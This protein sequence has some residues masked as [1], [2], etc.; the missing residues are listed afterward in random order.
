MTAASILRSRLYWIVLLLFL[1]TFLNYLDRQTLSI[2]KPTVK[3]EFGLDDGGYALLVN[4]FTFCYAAAYIGT[5]WIVDRFG[6]RRSLTIFLLGWSVAT[7]ACG[8]ARSFFAFAAFRALLGV[9][10]PG[11]FP[12]MVRA[13]TLWAPLRQ[14]GF[15]MSLAGAGGTVGA[16]AAAPLIAWLASAY[17]WHMAF[18]VPGVVGIL[19]AVAWWTV[20]REP[21]AAASEPDA[22][23]AKALPWRQL[24]CQRPMWGVILARLISDPVWYFCLFW[25]PGY[26]QEARGLSLRAAGMIGWIPFFVGNVGAL[27]LAAFSDHL[28]RRGVDSLRA[29]KRV[30]IGVA[31]PAPLI[32]LVPHTPGLAPTVALLSLA[33]IICLAWLLLLMPFIADMFP[34]GNVASVW[35]IAGSFGAAGAIVFNYC[36]GRVTSAFGSNLLF[37]VLGGLHLMAA[38]IIALLARRRDIA[39]HASDQTSPVRP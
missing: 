5:G 31:I 14:R 33:A 6:A 2:L 7:I 15:L 21:A 25:M 27:A 32:A 39:S 19:L 28:V 38:M 12:A 23:Q 24:W 18:V 3:A 13:T 37:L 17:S 22:A 16:V 29:R 26:F 20:F 11:N 35:A 9:M 8:L 10:E 1:A 30:L 4:I 36:V 34:A